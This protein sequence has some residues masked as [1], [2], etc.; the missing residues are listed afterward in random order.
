[1][2]TLF[3]GFVLLSATATWSADNFEPLNVKTGLWENTLT[4]T[5]G[6]EMPISSERLARLTPEQRARVLAT[7]KSSADQGARTITYKSCVTKE[8]LRQ[9]PFSEKRNCNETLLHSTSRQAEINFDCTLEGVKVTGT[10]Q[11]QAAG[12]ESIKGTGQGKASAEGRTMNTTS[13]LTG[14]WVQASCGDV[15]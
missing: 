12:D 5:I 3:W 2:R 13:T 6:G 14:K 11:I 10:I 7:L 8:N 1:M 4:T 15:K 9:S